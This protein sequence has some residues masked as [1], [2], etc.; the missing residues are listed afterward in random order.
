MTVLETIVT[1]FLAAPTTTMANRVLQPISTPALLRALADVM[2]DHPHFISELV[3]HYP[4]DS[5]GF[6]P[7]GESLDAP[8]TDVSLSARIVIGRRE[9]R[10]A[11]GVA[12]QRHGG[13][14]AAF[15]MPFELEQLQ[16]SGA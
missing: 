10:L 16:G 9:L 3:W 6:T 5:L 4:T 11:M 2:A 15:L 13:D 8:L 12:Y 7:K 14:P 1:D